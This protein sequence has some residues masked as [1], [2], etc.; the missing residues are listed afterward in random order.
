[1]EKPAA[2]TAAEQRRIQSRIDASDRTKGKKPDDH[3]PMQAGARRYPELPFP[4]QHQRK[5]GHEYKLDPDPFTTRRTILVRRSSRTRLRS[6]PAATAALVEA[7]PC[8]MRAKAP[9]FQSSI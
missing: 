3:Q 6:S 2:R 1:M 9:M 8:Y 7:S 5:P 4:K